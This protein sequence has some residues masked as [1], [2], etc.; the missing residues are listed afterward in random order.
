MARK[1]VRQQRRD[2]DTGCRDIQDNQ[3][4]PELGETEAGVKADPPECLK[5]AAVK[6]IKSWKRSYQDH[7]EPTTDLVCKEAEILERHWK[8]AARAIEDWFIEQAIV[9]VWSR[10][11]FRI[12]ILDPMLTWDT[13]DDVRRHL[14][15]LLFKE[16]EPKTRDRG[17]TG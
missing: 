6:V 5:I 17:A 16:L 4:R 8:A 11:S 14:R 13:Q 7:V 2:G 3:G 10:W 1:A 9:P 15:H 12:G